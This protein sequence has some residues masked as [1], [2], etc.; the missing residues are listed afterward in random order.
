MLYTGAAASE[1]KD[2][3]LVENDHDCYGIVFIICN[4]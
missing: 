3:N 2:E 1:A 4:S